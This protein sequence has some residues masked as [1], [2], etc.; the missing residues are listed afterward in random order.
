M[1]LTI[2]L[3]LNSPKFLKAVI[4]RSIVTMGE[5]DKVFWKDYLV[6]EKTNP[7]GSWVSSRVQLLTDMQES[8]SENAMLSHVVLV[9]WLA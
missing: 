1:L 6:Y 2:D 9:R 8:L 3:L 7:D 5:L 4:D